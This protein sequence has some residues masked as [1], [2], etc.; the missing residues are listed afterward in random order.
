[1]LT[2]INNYP[3]VVWSWPLVDRSP[4]VREVVPKSAQAN[5]WEYLSPNYR[6]NL[7]E[8]CESTAAKHD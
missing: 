4:K 8:P 6:E 3:T 5:V 7:P 1:M 2:I